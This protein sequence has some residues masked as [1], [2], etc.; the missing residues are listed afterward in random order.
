VGSFLLFF[1]F[2]EAIHKWHAHTLSETRR[3]FRLIIGGPEGPAVQPVLW[4]PG[5][6]ESPE[7]NTYVGERSAHDLLTTL[8]TMPMPKSGWTAFL[9]ELQFANPGGADMIFS[10]EV[11]II[12]NT[13]PFPDCHGE[14]CR[15]KLV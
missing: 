15:G 6:V 1:N 4:V 5:S 13:F 8:A 2:S 12:P 10:T 14:A 3:D 11:N 7:S 9:I